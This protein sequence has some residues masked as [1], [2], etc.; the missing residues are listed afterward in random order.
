[1]LYKPL[2]DSDTRKMLKAPDRSMYSGL[3]DFCLI[4]LMLDCGIRIGEA[5]K[6][7]VNDIDTRLGHAKATTTTSIYSHF[8]KRP[9]QEAADKLQNLFNKKPIDK[10]S[11]A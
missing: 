1:M 3:R 4:V 6:L 2:S 5:V 9:D 10:Q 11:E 8:L 7:K